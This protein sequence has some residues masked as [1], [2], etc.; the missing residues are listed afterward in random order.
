MIR[1]ILKFLK[2]EDGNV[3]SA[4]VIIPLMF[5]FLGSLQIMAIISTRNVEKSLAHDFAKSNAISL[6]LVNSP[7]SFLNTPP[8]FN[9]GLTP[10]LASES[11]TSIKSN[12]IFDNLSLV[13]IRIRKKIPHIFPWLSKIASTDEIRVAGAAIVEEIP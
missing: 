10:S 2:S 12:W 6:N 4:L 5:L 8:E 9:F 1:A 7:G 13:T 3:E 11:I